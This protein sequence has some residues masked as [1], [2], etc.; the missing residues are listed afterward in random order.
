M[1]TT[2]KKLTEGLANG[3]IKLYDDEYIA[4]TVSLTVRLAKLR[5]SS[6]RKISSSRLGVLVNAKPKKR[7]AQRKKKSAESTLKNS[8]LAKRFPFSE[9]AIKT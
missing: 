3:S 5:A 9:N 1:F 7:S 6:F 2:L 8:T 4:T